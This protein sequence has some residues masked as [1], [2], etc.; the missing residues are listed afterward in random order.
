MAGA[1][2]TGLGR[3][4]NSLIPE[5]SR[6]L[7]E[8][9]RETAEK[10]V[11]MLDIYQVEPD[12]GQPRKDFDEEKLRELA[13]SIRQ[14]GVLQPLLV[15]KVTGQDGVYYRI[16]AGE[17][18]W[19]AS[20]LAGLKEIP[21]IVKDYAPAEIFEI[22]LI[23]NIQREDLNPMEEAQAY[24][25]LQTEYGMT[26]EQMAEHIGKSRSQITNSLRLLNLSEEVAA[27]VARDELSFGHAKVLLGVSDPAR[28]L[29]L[30]QKAVDEGLSVRAL[31]ALLKE[32]P[33]G[34]EP[35]K[36]AAVSPV[37][38]RFAEELS[39][40]LGT[41]VNIVPGKR[42]GKIEIEYY[43]EDDLIRVSDLLMKVK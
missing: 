8:D 19:R 7:T 27:M 20:K 3:G 39:G 15:Q 29:A 37:V 41:R 13:D 1:R 10:T 11:T 18:R 12:R 16:I 42:K 9:F 35:K 40:A 23:E 22:S 38:E 21:A 32:K 33:A 28:Q 25:R 2:K 24:Q 43:S 5:G 6:L 4:V 36:E 34:K 14:F 31:E 26:H 17:R 30:A